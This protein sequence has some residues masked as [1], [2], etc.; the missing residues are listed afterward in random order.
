MSA[1]TPI[2]RP[3][4]DRVS[5]LNPEVRRNN[6]CNRHCC[7]FASLALT[8]L[9]GGAFVASIA[10]TQTSL[11]S[12]AIYPIATLTSQS[13]MA[14][15]AALIAYSGRQIPCKNH[16]KIVALIMLVTLVVSVCDSFLAN[17]VFADNDT[18]RA[19]VAFITGILVF[20]SDLMI[21]G[22]LTVPPRHLF[23]EPEPPAEQRVV[24]IEENQSLPIVPAIVPLEISDEP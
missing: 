15:G 22:T 20:F 10:I 7:F 14:L 21:Y 13:C 1:L 8:L 19:W 4:D 2:A 9:V 12:Y 24:V 6:R 5:L 23:E 16:V 18:G 17:R 3:M 11:S